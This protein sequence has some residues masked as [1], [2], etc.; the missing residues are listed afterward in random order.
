M[1][2]KT[3]TLKQLLACGLALLVS[4][5]AGATVRPVYNRCGPGLGT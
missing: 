1:L 3:S 4:A 5:Q 2:V